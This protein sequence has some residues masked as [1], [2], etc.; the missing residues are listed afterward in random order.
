MI[1]LFTCP[2]WD[3]IKTAVP[4]VVQL[5]LL[6]VRKTSIQQTETLIAMKTKKSVFSFSV[7]IQQIQFF[8]PSFWTVL[9][10]QSSANENFCLKNS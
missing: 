10:Q 4:D 5:Y 1:S 6:S 9:G 3:N 8:K 7:F 2:D